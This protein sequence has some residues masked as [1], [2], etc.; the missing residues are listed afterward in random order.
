MPRRHLQAWTTLLALAGVLLARPGDSAPNLRLRPPVAGCPVCDLWLQYE[1]VVLQAKQEVGPLKDG[2]LYFYHSDRPSVIEPL[3]RFAHERADLMDRLQTD[4][5]LM[6]QLGGP[7]GHDSEARAEISMEIST[8]ARGIFVLIR[9]PDPTT[10]WR[11]RFQAGRA[12][13]SQIPVWF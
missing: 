4:P 3:I 11:L 9:S 10:Y 1:D 13:R 8:S 5:E 7:C 12:V 6:E 2:I